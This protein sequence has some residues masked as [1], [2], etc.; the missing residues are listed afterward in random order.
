M[1]PRE[2]P[3]AGMVGELGVSSDGAVF[4]GIGLVPHFQGQVVPCYVPK[5]LGLLGERTRLPFHVDLKA[6]TNYLARIDP[7]IQMAQIL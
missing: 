3:L 7:M 2:Y 4:L 5:A 6:G 1:G